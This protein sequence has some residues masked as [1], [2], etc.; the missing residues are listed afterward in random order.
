MR[1]GT[2]E[3]GIESL[4]HHPQNAGLQLNRGRGQSAGSVIMAATKVLRRYQAFL[5][6]VSFGKRGSPRWRITKGNHGQAK[7]CVAGRGAGGPREK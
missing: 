6:A 7:C 3:N 2:T 1:T 5:Q 4:D